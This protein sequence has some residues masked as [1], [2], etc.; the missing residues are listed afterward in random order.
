MNPGDRLVVDM[1]DTANGFQVV[2]KD[3]TNHFIAI[4]ATRRTLSGSTN[5]CASR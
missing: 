3:L 2:I 4:S 1:Q 5:F